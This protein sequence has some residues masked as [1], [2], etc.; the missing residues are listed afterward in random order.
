[1]YD[2][3]PAEMHCV[4]HSNLSPSLTESRRICQGRAG[5]LPDCSPQTGRLGQSKKEK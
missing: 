5:E 2:I 3:L 4:K 1:M